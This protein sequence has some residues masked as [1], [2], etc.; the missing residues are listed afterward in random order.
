MLYHVVDASCYIRNTRWSVFKSSAP[1]TLPISKYQLQS[2]SSIEKFMTDPI[3][4]VVLSIELGTL[5]VDILIPC[6][7]VDV[8]Y[9]RRHVSY[10]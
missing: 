1:C 6:I 7:K 4:C 3:L 9:C 10:W 5:D 2:P 8:F